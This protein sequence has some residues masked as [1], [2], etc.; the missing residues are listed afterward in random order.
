MKT[1][2]NSFVSLLL[3]LSFTAA[4][5]PVA[6]TSHSCCGALAADLQDNAGAVRPSF[7]GEW[8]V[9]GGA[10]AL[11]AGFAVSAVAASQETASRALTITGG[12]LLVGGFAAAAAGVGVITTRSIPS[13]RI[14]YCERYAGPEAT[15][16]YV[17][18]MAVAKAVGIAGTA[19]CAAS[20]GV[21]L[22]GPALKLPAV[23]DDRAN[24]M[25]LA[26]VALMGAGLVTAVMGDNVYY[27]HA[28]HGAA[29]LTAG[30]QEHGAGLALV[31]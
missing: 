10:T 25:G 16:T 7:T 18:T 3:V 1:I 5:A 31:F 11:A 26:G 12:T 23:W 6:E 8:L 19:L 27:I 14:G 29:H 22:A 13:Y 15:R 17:C 28:R 4:H 21:T 24:V 2:L 9:A 30:L 20:L